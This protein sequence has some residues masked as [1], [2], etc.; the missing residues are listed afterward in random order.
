MSHAPTMGSH[1]NPGSCVCGRPVYVTRCGTPYIRIQCGTPGIRRFYNAW[2]EPT[3]GEGPTNS[4]CN[5]AVSAF[6][7]DMQKEKART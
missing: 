6:L 4:C 5:R 1:E 3:V 2:V 7:E